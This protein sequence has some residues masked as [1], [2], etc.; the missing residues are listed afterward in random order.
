MNLYE[1]L[2]LN[3]NASENEIKKAYHK[4]AL[5]YHPDKNKDPKAKEKFQNIQSAY[6]ILSNPKT[7][8][9]YSKLNRVDQ[10]N[11]V[12]LLQKIFSICTLFLI[13]YYIL[14]IL[15]TNN[16]LLNGYQMLSVERIYI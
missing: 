7:R 13:W 15:Y 12:D 1:I 2:E 3:N 11:F 10:H 4:L 8:I 14:V 16:K 6:Q 9:D 5:K